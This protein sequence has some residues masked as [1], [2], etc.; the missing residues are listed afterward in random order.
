MKEKKVE[1]TESTGQK[2]DTEDSPKSKKKLYSIIS[3]FVALGIALAVLFFI[4]NNMYAP[5]KNWRLLKML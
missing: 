1:K 3:I 2:N 4:G 5:E